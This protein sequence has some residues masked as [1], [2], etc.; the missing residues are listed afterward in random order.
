M[1]R[2]LL[3]FILFPVLSFSQNYEDED[4][5]YL[6]RHENIKISLNEGTFDIIQDITE[7]GKFLSSKN[8]FYAN[9]N[10][11]YNLNFTQVKNIDAYTYFPDTKKKI[12]VDYIETQQ[13]FDDMMFYGEDEYKSFI[14]PAVTKGAETFLN[15]EV[16]VSEPHFIGDF[17]FASTIPIK[18]AKL[19]LEFPK[20][21]EI[22]Y[23]EFNT[24]GIDLTFE[25]K[26][27]ESNY[28]YTWTAN[29]S[30][31]FEFESDSEAPTYYLPHIIYYI[32][33]YTYNN[34]TKGVSG[35]I[36]NLY[37]WYVDLVKQTDRK[38]LDKV[39]AIADEIT[40][41]LTNDKDRAKAIFKWVQKNISYVFFAEGLGG[42]IPAGAAS[43]CESRY[44]DCKAMSNLLYEMLN[45]VG[46]KAYRTWIGSRSKPYSYH[47][48]PS[49]Y[50][51]DHVI[52]TAVIEKDTIFLDAT[53]SYVPF[54]MPSGFIQNKE[55]LMGID[56]ENYKIIKVPVQPSGLSVTETKSSMTIENGI[57]KVYEQ[58]VLTGYEKV[59]FITDYTFKK[60]SKTDE[61]FLNIILPLGNNKTKY[62][63]FSKVNFDHNNLP[64][65]LSYELEID[66][67]IKTIGNK[68]YIKPNIDTSLSSSDIDIKNRKHSKKIDYQFEKHFTTNF[69]VPEGYSASYIPDE[70]SFKDDH[71]GFTISYET[72]DNII[73]Q[74]KSIY[75]KTLSIKKEDFEN[76]NSFIKK[77]RKAYKKSIILEQVQ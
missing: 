36:D 26:E 12:T 63:N 42:F 13:Q 20:N 19:T 25:K 49:V 38:D 55:G 41:G 10:I 35:T 58:R 23:S 16:H 64:L 17:N 29:N 18:N 32:K 77:L 68:I 48:L 11:P 33:N 31:G 71:Y 7:H 67:Y 43:T 6:K 51:D 69:K 57:V 47:E 65:E 70:I 66:S 24:E 37:S 4:Y 15:Y 21:V 28:I 9:V 76:W 73:T 14:F 5:V 54:G 52:A 3:L 75:I 72:N 59:E 34:E 39:Y 22:G 74:T 60:D 50:V 1:R 56:D 62:S 45:H 8:L 53:N 30:E 46:I 2:F 40:K 44:G 27:T 61:E